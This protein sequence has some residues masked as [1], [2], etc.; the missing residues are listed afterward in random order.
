MGVVGELYETRRNCRAADLIEEQQKQLGRC[1]AWGVGEQLKKMCL[2]DR[3]IAALVEKDLESP[4]MGLAEA[5]KKIREFA[6]K[7]GGFATEE[8]GERILRA[9]T[10]AVYRRTLGEPLSERLMRYGVSPER[11]ERYL[12]REDERGRILADTWDMSARLGLDMTDP[13]ILFPKGLRAT[14]DRLAPAVAE[15]KKREES[16]KIRAQFQALIDRYGHLEWSDG[17]ICIRLPRSIAELVREGAVLHHCVGGYGD[18]HLSG[19]DVIFF[20][21]HARRPERSWYTLDIRMTGAQPREVQLHGYKNELVHG[22]ELHIPRRVREFCDRWEREVLL[23]GWK[24]AQ[25][26]AKQPKKQAKKENAA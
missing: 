7:N 1:H 3:R 18:K 25:R 10:W 23:P 4:G 22:R 17:D 20:V 24:R 12:L 16:E 15:L 2:K 13:Q 19:S 21:R 5:E 26:Q 11:A 9:Q 8:E 6:M 14:H